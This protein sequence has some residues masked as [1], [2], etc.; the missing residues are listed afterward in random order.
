[1]RR[2]GLILIAAL[3][4]IA[5]N[6]MATPGNIEGTW[7][8]QYDPTVFAM[9][10]YVEYTFSPDN[11]YQLQAYDALSNESFTSTGRYLLSTVKRTITM[12]PDKSDY[13]NVTYKIVKLT[14]TEMEWQQVGT[15]YSVG[16]WGSEYRH[17]IRIK[18]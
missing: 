12:N 13:T 10:G 17:F 9:D 2:I 1:M 8:E 4:V 18:Q 14:S 7:S 3:S 11:Q 6:K 16:T 5:C 15:T